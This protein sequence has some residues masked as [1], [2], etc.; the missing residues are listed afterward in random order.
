VERGYFVL[1]QPVPLALRSVASPQ[2]LERGCVNAIA[3]ETIKEQ[4][5]ARWPKMRDSVISRLEGLLR[6]VLGPTDFF[7]PLTDAAYLVTMPAADAQEVKIVCLRVAYEL[8]KSLLGRCDL[9]HIQVSVAKSGGTDLL[10]LDS[11]PPEEIASLSERAGIREFSETPYVNEAGMGT[12]SS[13]ETSLSYLPVWD[14]RNEAITTY[15]CRSRAHR[16]LEAFAEPVAQQHLSLKDRV[17]IEL[18]ALH[19]G[20]AELVR[21]LRTGQRFLL[22]IPLSFD[23]IGTPLGRM[24]LASACRHLLAEHRQYLVFVLTNV[25]PGV[26]QTKLADIT[27]ALRPFAR[28]VMATVAPGARNYAGYEGIGLQ[29][30]GLDLPDGA[31]AARVEADVARL[32][33]AARTMKLG[34]FV[35]GIAA[36][37]TLAIARDTNIRWLSGPAIL[38]LAQKPQAMSRF[39]IDNL[40]P[41]VTGVAAA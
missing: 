12:G 36:Q 35:N 31:N 7:A 27:N 13:V 11:L 25:P 32:A 37:D 33:I 21:N 15:L 34:T 17:Q 22:G 40:T 23:M 29:A 20:I 8:H 3:F 39:T 38:P 16:L 10:S 19:A 14:T 26:A 4:A 2:L 5:G 6:H 30:I 41:D 1:L 18:E 9:G 24:E 28:S